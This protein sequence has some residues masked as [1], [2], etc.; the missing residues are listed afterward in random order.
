MNIEELI[1]EFYYLKNDRK[2]RRLEFHGPDRVFN[3]MPTEVAVRLKME[4]LIE[5]IGLASKK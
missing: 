4:E 3:E 2:R 1:E 5:K